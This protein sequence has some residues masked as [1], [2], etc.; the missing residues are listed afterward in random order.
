[1]IYL[2]TTSSRPISGGNYM[3]KELES[4]IKKV[5][6]EVKAWQRIPTSVNGVYLVKTPA[7]G[8]NE[9]IMVEINPINE[10]GTPM[11]RR[12]LFLKNTSEFNGFGDIFGNDKVLDLLG[13]LENISG[14][15]KI[16]EIKAVEI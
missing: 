11:K 3:V 8:S 1:M 10:R 9:T 6:E 12:G 4:K 16:K 15:E 13:T 14:G 2:Y 5:L 7:D